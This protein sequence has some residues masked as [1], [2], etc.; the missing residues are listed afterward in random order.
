MDTNI[1]LFRLTEDTILFI[2]TLQNSWDPFIT[3]C[4]NYSTPGFCSSF[5]FMISI[6]PRTKYAVVMLCG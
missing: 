2:I 3:M 4:T 1:E 6:L 5:D